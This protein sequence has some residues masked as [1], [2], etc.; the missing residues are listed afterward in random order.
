[1]ADDPRE[2]RAVLKRARRKAK[3]KGGK[4]AQGRVS[5]KIRHLVETHEVPNTKAGRAQ[6]AAMAFSM[7]RAH[8]LGPHG[9]YRR[10]KHG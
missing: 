1:M 10:V 7:E 9:E 3:R 2:K 6:A 8:R 4:E 5:E